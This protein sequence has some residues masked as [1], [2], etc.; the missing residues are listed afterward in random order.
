MKKLVKEY[1]DFEYEDF[2]GT[3]RAEWDNNFITFKGVDYMPTVRRNKRTGESEWYF[4]DALECCTAANPKPLTAAY[5]TLDE[6]LA[7]PVFDGKTI[8]ERYGEMG[9]CNMFWIENCADS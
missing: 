6:L 3:M 7:A 1:G 4:A 9:K 2:I 5:K 8:A